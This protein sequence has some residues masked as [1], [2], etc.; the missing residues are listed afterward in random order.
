[1]REKGKTGGA[2]EVKKVEVLNSDVPT[3]SVSYAQRN[4]AQGIKAGIEGKNFKD[5]QD[6]ALNIEK[7][8]ELLK[9]QLEKLKKSKKVPNELNK[10]LEKLNKKLN[11]F[12]KELKVEIDKELHIPVFKII[13]K[14]THQ[15]IRQVPWEEVLKFLRNLFKLLQQ[16]SVRH[17]DLK[18]LFFKKEV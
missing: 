4:S 6:K 13:D 10:L 14:D 2:M 12:D 7:N 3:V 16:E 18:G 15:V 11:P 17:E 1:L 9:S 8:D 5:V